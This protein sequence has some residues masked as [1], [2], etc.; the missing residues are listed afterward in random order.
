[1]TKCAHWRCI[2]KVNLRVLLAALRLTNVEQSG[3]F[4]RPVGVGRFRWMPSF[5]QVDPHRK[6]DIV[7]NIVV[8]CV[9]NMSSSSVEF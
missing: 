5:Q 3:R 1:M 7:Y 4:S 9:Q 2:G 6:Y 8:A